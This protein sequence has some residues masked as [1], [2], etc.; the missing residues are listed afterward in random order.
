MNACRYMSTEQ[1]AIAELPA[2]NATP[3]V[4]QS[5]KIKLDSLDAILHSMQH[6][7]KAC[8]ATG[9]ERYKVPLATSH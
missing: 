5:I 4:Q 7:S 8:K 6:A 3:A 1:D 9:A 2:L